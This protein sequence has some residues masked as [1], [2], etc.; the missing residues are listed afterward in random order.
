MNCNKCGS[1]RGICPVKFGLALGIT[2]GVF[3]MLLAWV[4]AWWGWGSDLVSNYGNYLTGY[5]ATFMGG[6]IGGLWGFV[7]GFVFGF[8]LIMVYYAISCCS[9][10]M[11]CKCGCCGSKECGSKDCGSKECGSKECK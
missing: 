1:C 5:E 6:L 2:C 4:A 10:S 3:M 11:C 7:K 8:V 9:K